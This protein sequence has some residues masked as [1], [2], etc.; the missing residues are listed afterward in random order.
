MELKDIISKITINKEWHE[1]YCKLVPQ[2]IES[3]KSCR[4]WTDWEKDL[5]YEFF[6]REDGHCVS[7]L[8]QG[9]FTSE[10]KFKIKENWKDLAP[11]LKEIAEQ[12][13]SQ[14]SFTTKYIVSLVKLRTKKGRQQQ[15]V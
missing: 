4:D 9:Y 15:I 10:E 3:A 14:R 12:P 6:E 1:R 5:F 13:K 7:S 8:R 2:F 11:I